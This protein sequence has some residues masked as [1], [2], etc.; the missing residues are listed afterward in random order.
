[1]TEPVPTATV[2]ARA[3]PNT[4]AVSVIVTVATLRDTEEERT[5]DEAVAVIEYDEADWYV[6]VV[7]EAEPPE[8]KVTD[9]DP[10]SAVPPSAV[11]VIVIA[12]VIPPPSV[13]FTAAWN[14]PVIDPAVST[15]CPE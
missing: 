3:Q 14:E 13:A 5:N 10:E 2:P 11:Q 12:D 7:T 1:M 4:P 6:A 9:P 15:I 8:G